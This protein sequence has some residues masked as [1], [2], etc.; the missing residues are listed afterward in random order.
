MKSQNSISKSR[1]NYYVDIASLLPFLL[2]LITGIIM[3]QYHAGKPVL[4]NTL[5]QNAEFW[6]PVHVILAI[7]TVIL[8]SIHLFLHLSWFEK[9]F[10]GKL[11]NKFWI[12]NLT[13]VILFLLT[14]ITSFVPLLILGESNATGLLLGLHNK[15]GLLLIVFFVIHLYSYFGW[16]VNMTKKVLK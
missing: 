10:S 12:R 8:I 6:L 9:L 1:R 5:G 11:N 16:L 3:L 13:L 4:E 15:I 14:T 2:L 7:I